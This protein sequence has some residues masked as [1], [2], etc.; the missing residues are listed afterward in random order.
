MGH[1]LQIA[2]PDRER[3][4][5]RS[6]CPRSSGFTLIEVLV[7]VLIISA[8]LGMVT[9]RLTRD[10]RDLVRDE[11]DRFVILL[12][13]ARDESILRGGLLALEMDAEGYRFLQPSQD[14]EKDEF[15]PMHDSPFTPRRF[16]PHMDVH[17]EIEG[18]V[19]GER[20]GLVL[21]PGGN[22]PAFSVVFTLN[23]SR[24]WVIGSQ[25]GKIRSVQT[26]DAQAG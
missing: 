17:L 6:G 3:R 22:L 4:R 18:Q 10:D 20:Q 16:P 9:L 11:A 8:V 2:R 15:V 21:D 24:W 25:D 1:R 13:T 14:K 23:E 5:T 7:V 12:Q 26:P 19:S